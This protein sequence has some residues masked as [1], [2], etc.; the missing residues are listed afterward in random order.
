MQKITRQDVKTLQEY[1][2]HRD[3][4]RREVIELKKARRISVG[5]CVTMVFENRQTVIH[6]IQEM[7]R[8]EHLYDEASIQH[9]IDTYNRL[10]PGD[11]ELSATLFIEIADAD[12]IKPTLDRLRGLDQG[13]CVRL[14]VDEETAIPGM[15]EAGHSSE[16]K[17]SAVH[18]VRFRLDARAQALLRRAPSPKLVIDHPQYRAEAPIR[19]ETRQ[20]LLRDLGLSGTPVEASA[21]GQ[22]V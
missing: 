9:E 7:M 6:Q 1:E 5:D 14:L 3:R 8:A 12:Q 16:E 21:H 22:S 11:G 17:I 13:P 18:Y 15:F 10:I 4:L 19:E 20:E 2:P